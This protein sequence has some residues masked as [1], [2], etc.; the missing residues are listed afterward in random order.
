M[1]NGKWRVENEVL[2]MNIGVRDIAATIRSPIYHLRLII[3][4]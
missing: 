1:E 4:L 3:H 2:A